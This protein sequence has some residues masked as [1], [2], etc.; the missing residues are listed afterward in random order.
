[1]VR[2]NPSSSPQMA[3]ALQMGPREAQHYGEGLATSEGRIT[4]QRAELSFTGFEKQIG[5]ED[6]LRDRHRHRERERLT[7]PSPAQQEGRTEGLLVE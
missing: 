6:S 2:D 1:M 3:S 4:H 7:P 5:L